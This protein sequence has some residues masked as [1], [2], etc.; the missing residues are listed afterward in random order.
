MKIGDEGQQKRT[1]DE[2]LGDSYHPIL[3]IGGVCNRSKKFWPL[4]PVRYIEETKR[5]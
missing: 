1:Y 3:S 4:T 2:P 5:P